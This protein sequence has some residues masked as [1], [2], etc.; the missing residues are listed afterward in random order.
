VIVRESRVMTG[1][2]FAEYGRRHTD[3]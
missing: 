3:G 2:P 1:A